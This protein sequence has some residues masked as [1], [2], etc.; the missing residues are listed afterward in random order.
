MLAAPV[1]TVDP[2]IFAY[3]SSSEQNKLGRRELVRQ[4]PKGE[5]TESVQLLRCVGV[6]VIAAMMLIV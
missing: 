5:V 1:L 2:T 6:H 4:I 3:W